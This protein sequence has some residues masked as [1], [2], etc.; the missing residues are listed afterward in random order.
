MN[1]P[2]HETLWHGGRPGSTFG[3]LPLRM[4]V[5]N[6][7][8]IGNFCN[9]RNQIKNSRLKVSILIKEMPA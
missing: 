1:D 2:F 9:C 3:E 8:L 4:W 6:E 7:L 5:L